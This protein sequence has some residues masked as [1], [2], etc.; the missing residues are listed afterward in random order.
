MLS[1]SELLRK[2]K[3][4]KN[5]KE[6]VDD[7]FKRAPEIEETKDFA[8]NEIE[9]ELMGRFFDSIWELLNPDTTQ[10]V[11]LPLL[12]SRD[13]VSSRTM[14]SILVHTWHQQC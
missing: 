12:V 2:S 14:A 11:E 3:F 9:E 8:T 4:Y 7:A 5:A 10:E 13:P 6:G 1:F